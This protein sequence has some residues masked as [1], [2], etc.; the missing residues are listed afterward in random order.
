MTGCELSKDQ[1]EELRLSTVVHRSVDDKELKDAAL[2]RASDSHDKSQAV[3]AE[4]TDNEDESPANANRYAQPDGDED[5]VLKNT[6][7]ATVKD[8]LLNVEELSDLYR[9]WKGR[10]YSLYGRNAFRLSNEVGN[11]HG[12]RDKEVVHCPDL[13]NPDEELLRRGYFE[14]A[15]TNSM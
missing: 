5:R 13:T 10:L 14:P 3:N 1:E 4:N 9:P 15:Y 11:F 6:R 2:A 12:Q 8:G 7:P